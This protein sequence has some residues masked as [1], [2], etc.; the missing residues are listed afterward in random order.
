MLDRTINLIIFT[1]T[2]TTSFAGCKLD[3]EHCIGDCELLTA[4][5]EP[6]MTTTSTG[7]ATSTVGTT[8]TG[9]ATTEGTTET[10]GAPVC[11]CILDDPEGEWPSQPICG[12]SLCPTIN[13]ENSC[14][15]G[16]G[17]DPDRVF[18]N[19][20]ALECALAA[21]R[22]RTPGLVEWSCNHE[23]GLTWEKGYVLIGDDGTAV[24]RRWN[25][26]DLSYVTGEAL[27][28]VL[29]DSDVF[30]QCLT[31]DVGDRYSCLRHV[32]LEAP[33]LVCDEGWEFHAV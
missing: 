3:S 1:V 19:P 22:D 27:Q 28:G 26:Y 21:L 16:V 10:G 11:P 6:D 30:E 24:W 8:E 33:L 18:L 2:T 9:G 7:G 31:K 14:E 12:E 29:P 5:T 17:D 20:E 4:G 32:M 23:S 15:W 25:W 13:V